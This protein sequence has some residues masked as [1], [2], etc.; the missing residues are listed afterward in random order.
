MKKKQIKEGTIVDI[1]K[2]MI[3][4]YHEKGGKPNGTNNIDVSMTDEG[5]IR[6]EYPD[7]S[8]M[9]TFSILVDKYGKLAYKDFYMIDCLLYN[10]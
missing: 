6:V 3:F 4:W 10:K 9:G 8:S 5:M 7:F 2:P 1:S